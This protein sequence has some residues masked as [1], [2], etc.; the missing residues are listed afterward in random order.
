M[1]FY[2]KIVNVKMLL[3]SAYLDYSCATNPFGDLT[4]EEKEDHIRKTSRLLEKARRDLEEAQRMTAEVY[5]I[6]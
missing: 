1:T 6:D 4:P 2:E 3:D 5:E